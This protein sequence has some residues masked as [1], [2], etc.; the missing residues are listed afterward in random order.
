MI[1]TNTTSDTNVTPPNTGR[2]NG[3]I[4]L[5]FLQRSDP[6]RSREL[7]SVG[8]VAFAESEPP[9]EPVSAVTELELAAAAA[10]P[11]FA[12]KLATLSIALLSRPV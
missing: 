4:E 5:Q 3:Q 12:A 9:P 7:D 1:K 11:R 8:L 10:L 2:A 6:E